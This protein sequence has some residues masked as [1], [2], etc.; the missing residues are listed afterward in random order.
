MYVC[1][2]VCVCVDVYV[3]LGL[4]ACYELIV[5]YVRFFMLCN[6]HIF[7]LC[8]VRTFKLFCG[9]IITMGN[10]LFL[11]LHMY[12]EQVDG[13]SSG[14]CWTEPVTGLKITWP[15]RRKRYT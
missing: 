7:T 2:Y 12:I 1:E 13:E 5:S 8:S 3:C 15:I 14:G 10:V 6:M 4:C 9:R 11:G